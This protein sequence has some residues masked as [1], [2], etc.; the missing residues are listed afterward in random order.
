MISLRWSDPL[1][2]NTSPP[3]RTGSGAA[4]QRTQGPSPSSRRRRER[5]S[6]LRS[7]RSRSTRDLKA[8]TPVGAPTKT[9]AHGGEMTNL[10]D[11]RPGR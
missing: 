1:E 11:A 6:S 8:H 10:H 7:R 9:A 3:E 4:H 2:T 5:R